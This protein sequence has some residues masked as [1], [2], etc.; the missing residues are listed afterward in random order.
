MN[1]QIRL[2]LTAGTTPGVFDQFHRGVYPVRAIP[3]LHVSQ[4]AS[5]VP[6]DAKVGG[7]ACLQVCVRLAASSNGW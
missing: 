1:A 4:H 2:Q 7:V 3:V 5:V 6:E